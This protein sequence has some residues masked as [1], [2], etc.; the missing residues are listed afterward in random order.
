MSLSRNLRASLSVSLAALSLAAGCR[1]DPVPQDI[2][3][4]LGEEQGEP[5]ANHRSGQ[6]CLVCHSTYGG[7]QPALAVAGTLY[8]KGDDGSIFPAA[9]VPVTI[10]DSSGELPKKACTNAGGNF[11]IKR[12]DW[13]TITFPLAALR[14]GD[15]EMRS[16][17]GTDGS[18]ASCHKLPPKQNPNPDTGFSYDPITG[19]GPDSVG[20]ILIDIKSPASICNGG[21]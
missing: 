1:Y 8:G 6:P 14:A 20:V 16:L 10:L 13:E 11:F 21:T 17:I 7:A 5:N 18:C 3:D 15:R 12:D 19:A 2:I 9:N 4:E